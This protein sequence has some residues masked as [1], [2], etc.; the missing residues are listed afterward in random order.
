MAG[1]ASRSPLPDGVMP[2]VPMA[3]KARRRHRRIHG[4][5]PSSIPVT[6]PHPTGSRS[7]QPRS[8]AN[9]ATSDLIGPPPPDTS[10]HSSSKTH[11]HK[12]TP[13]ES[14]T[15]Q[16]QE[17]DTTAKTHHKTVHHG[18]E[19]SGISHESSHQTPI[20]SNKARPTLNDG[21]QTPNVDADGNTRESVPEDVKK[22]NA[23]ME[24]RH[25]RTYNQLGR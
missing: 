19:H 6:S 16:P 9:H 7:S 25:D 4:H 17:H 2:T 3:V 12:A 23:E 21:A 1:G 14:E 20:P 5:S 24:E 8:F 11:S 10:T 22:H 15:H 18:R 13:S